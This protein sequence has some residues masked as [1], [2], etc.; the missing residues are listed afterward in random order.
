MNP[1][2]ERHRPKS[3]LEVKGQDD[4]IKRI[5]EFITSFNLMKIAGNKNQK[6]ALLLYGPPGTGKTTLAYVAS[7]ETNSE[8]FELNASDFRNKN[9]LQEV[10]KPAMQQQSL[11]KQS[12]II[13]VDEADGILG[14]DRGGIP[15]LV[16]LIQDSMYPL[17]ITANDA[18]SKKMSPLRKLCELIEIKE[19]NYR[20]IKEA[21]ITILRKEGKFI[22]NEVLTQIAVKSRGDLRAAINDLQTISKIKDPSNIAFDERN[23][24]IDIFHAL[25]KIFKL[26]ATKETSTIFDD[27]KMPLDEIML[28]IEENIPKEYSGIE[29]VKAIESLSKADIFKG[30]IYKQQYW[31]FMLYENILLSYGVAAAKKESKEGFTKYQKPSRILKIWMN[32]KKTAKK[33]TIAEKYAKTVHIGIKRAMQEFPIIKQ[34]IKSNPKIQEELKLDSE[35]VEYLEV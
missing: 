16:K 15:E 34:I 14:T 21:M 7:N 29:L 2:T 31:R 23:K 19:I 32:N 28:W 17:I 5:K 3:F 9:K 18:W 12:K 24:Q 8:I 26:K 35:E 27:V 33:K 4:A 11:T 1:W 30:R 6:K 10:L 13:L 22:E 20:K 25:K